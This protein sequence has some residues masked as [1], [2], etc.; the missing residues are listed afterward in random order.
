[1][2]MYEK[3]DDALADALAQPF[4]PECVK[5]LRKGGAPIPFIS[6]HFYAARL[7]AL[8]GPEGW[9]M[10]TP[11]LHDLAGKLVVG[12]PVSILGVTKI[13]FGTEDEGKDDF[14]DAATNAWAMAF[15]RT[16]ALFGMGLYMYDK[17]RRN[18][19]PAA[20]RPAPAAAQSNGNAPALASEAQL[21]RL[22]ALAK[23]AGWSGDALRFYLHGCGHSTKAVPRE[24]YNDICADMQDAELLARVVADMANTGAAA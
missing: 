4:P 15:K 12:L 7:N 18:A 20:P 16:L 19:A 5:Q 22:F 9:S 3:W 8:V 2:A 13:N 24:K 23:D 10:G 21:K 6:W 11:I 14:G 1:M 17:D